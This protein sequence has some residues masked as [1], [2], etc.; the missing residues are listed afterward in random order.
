VGRGQEVVREREEKQKQ[1]NF[2]FCVILKISQNSAIKSLNN[3][4]NNV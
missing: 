3:L 2:P 1:D 4:I